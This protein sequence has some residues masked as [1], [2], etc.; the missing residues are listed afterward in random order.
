MAQRDPAGEHTRLLIA[1]HLRASALMLA[2]LAAAFVVA[3]GVRYAHRDD[4][5]VIDRILDPLAES[6]L[7]NELFASVDTHFI[8]L[9]D[10]QQFVPLLV[11]AAVLAGLL[12]GRSALELIALS[13]ATAVFATKILLKPVVGRLHSGELAFPS[14]HVTAVSAL[15]LAASLLVL[16]AGRPRQLWLRSLLCVALLSVAVTTS[17]SVVAERT[18][19]TTDVLAGWG[20][21]LV[22][23]IMTALVLDSFGAYAGKA[24]PT[25]RE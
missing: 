16:S 23:V 12:R 15:A 18:H 9:G 13:T 14:S 4:A 10:V 25:P 2:A 5:G 7:G 1:V 3:T 24:H 22:S 17:V 8:Q 20:V 21:S 6:L 11:V 19:Y